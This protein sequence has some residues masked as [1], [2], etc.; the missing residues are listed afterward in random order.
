VRED[1]HDVMYEDGEVSYD[2]LRAYR[3]WACCESVLHMG[4]KSL[5][6]SIVSDKRRRRRPPCN[7]LPNF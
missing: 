2:V 4:R 1:H 7:G 3:E 6:C 5:F